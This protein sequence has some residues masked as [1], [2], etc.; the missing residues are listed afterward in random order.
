[1]SGAGAPGR[2]PAERYLAIRD[3]D[4]DPLLLTRCSACSF[5]LRAF[6]VVPEAATT[7]TIEGYALSDRAATS[8]ALYRTGERFLAV[9][10]FAEGRAP[11]GADLL[12]LERGRALYFLDRPEAAARF[13]SLLDGALDVPCADALERATKAGASECWIAEP[14]TAVA[15]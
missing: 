7:V 12:D 11:S 2:G 14:A 9:V 4:L 8:T 1:V 13:P 15:P 5:H 3:R 6:P 10:R